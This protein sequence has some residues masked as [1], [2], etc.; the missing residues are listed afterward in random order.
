MSLKFNEKTLIALKQEQQLV[1][2]K[3]TAEFGQFTV[4]GW[5]VHDFYKANVIL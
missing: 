1:R 3:S 4:L 2:R 5:T